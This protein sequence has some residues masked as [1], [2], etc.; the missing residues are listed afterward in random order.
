MPMLSR[1]SPRPY[2]SK[3][4]LA[5]RISKIQVSLCT[6][7]DALKDTAHSKSL[8]RIQIFTPC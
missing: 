1:S 8:L 3:V 5:P 4:L 7:C 2:G 6:E